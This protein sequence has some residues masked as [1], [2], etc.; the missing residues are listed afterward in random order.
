MTYRPEDILPDNSDSVDVNGTTVRK[1]TVAAVLSNVKLLLKDNKSPDFNSPEGLEVIRA[2]NEAL[3]PLGFYKLLSWNNRELNERLAK[4]RNVQKLTE[5]EVVYTPQLTPRKED[6]VVWEH[7]IEVIEN[8]R[9]IEPQNPEV[10]KMLKLLKV[11]S[12][13]F[14]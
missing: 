3:V 9:N 7:I 4:E 6:K 13:W 10:V 14:N 11:H 5:E 8:L 12:T 1:G 2:S